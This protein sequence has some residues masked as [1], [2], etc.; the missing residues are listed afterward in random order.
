MSRSDED[1]KDYLLQVEKLCN[2]EHFL[3]PP[4]NHNMSI[5]QLFDYDN[6]ATT[7]TLDVLLNIKSHK[8]KEEDDDKFAFDDIIEAYE[9]MRRYITLP[10]T[11][12]TLEEFFLIGGIRKYCVNF[13]RK[14]LIELK[15]HLHRYLSSIGT[16]SGVCF[17]K[18][19]K[20]CKENNFGIRVV[21]SE[22]FDEGDELEYVT[23]C[24][25]YLDEEDKKT[26]IKPGINDFSI[27]ESKSGEKDVCLLGPAS[28][29]NH[30]C[31]PNV[32]YEC[33]GGDVITIVAI[34]DI[35]VGDELFV[36]YGKNFFGKNNVDCKCNTCDQ[37]KKKEA[38]VLKWVPIMCRELPENIIDCMVLI[39]LRNSIIKQ[40][41]NGNILKKNLI[42]A[43]DYL[44][45]Y[46]EFGLGVDKIAEIS[47]ELDFVKHIKEYIC[48]S[49][50]C[51]IYSETIDNNT[52]A[53][54]DKMFIL[55]G[56]GTTAGKLLATPDKTEVGKHLTNLDEI[57]FSGERLFTLEF[58]HS[59]F[60]N[61][62]ANDIYAFQNLLLEQHFSFG[63]SLAQIVAVLRHFIDIIKNDEAIVSI[64]NR[65]KVGRGRKA[66][67][68]DPKMG[69]FYNK[70]ILDRLHLDIFGGKV[71][72]EQFQ[73]LVNCVKKDS[74]NEDDSYSLV[75]HG[76]YPSL[77]NVYELK[78]ENLEGY[79]GLSNDFRMNVISGI[80][81][82]DIEYTNNVLH[83]DGLICETFNKI[84]KHFNISNRAHFV[85]LQSEL[86]KHFKYGT[87]GFDT[88]F[89]FFELIDPNA[90]EL[91]QPTKRQ[92]NRRN[93][94]VEINN[95]AKSFVDNWIKAIYYNIKLERLRGIR[96]NERREAARKLHEERKEARRMAR[97]E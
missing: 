35:N 1:M 90:V 19:Y 92:K 3:C 64:A 81:N 87:L 57:N 68:F 96:K 67:T 5:R 93:L 84:T 71:K 77:P 78:Y 82:Y 91:K 70:T 73:Y 14:E 85:K 94:Y 28:F 72:K 44:A 33:K 97:N 21:A 63:I 32:K 88:D 39:T 2:V 55:K 50:E 20:N 27:M 42:L 51:G 4:L 89:E 79:F 37:Q 30:D 56:I 62:L 65:A 26:Y 24:F 75:I 53:L 60:N 18:N 86:D 41:I 46:V 58:Y 48:C 8:M 11:R 13:S 74:K 59:I 38:N 43:L 45:C 31:N 40:F 16:H 15:N 61:E 6:I 17:E 7:I 49:Y 25:V 22:E 23:G 76:C 54:F 36:S 10:M 29:I 69:Y 12:R 66:S 52:H 80:D 47:E 95:V 34:K 83:V 9:I